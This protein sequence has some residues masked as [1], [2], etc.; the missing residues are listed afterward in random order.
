MSTVAVS[1][2]AGR[3]LCSRLA[4]GM[5]LVVLGPGRLLCWHFPGFRRVGEEVGCGSSLP[6][7]VAPWV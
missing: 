7:R 4:P 2:P 3:P 5:P 6:Q 1:A